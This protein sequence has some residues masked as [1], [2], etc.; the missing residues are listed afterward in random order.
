MKAFKYW[1]GRN[2][3]TGEKENWE[4]LEYSNFHH[5]LAKGRY[6]YFKY[7]PKCIVIIPFEA[8]FVITHGTVEDQLKH[9]ESHPEEDWKKIDDLAFVLKAEYEDWL[10]YHKGEYKLNEKT[11][12]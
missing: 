2:F 1:N 11:G 6:R 8:H 4:E 12:T 3:L 5:I 10:K 9:M 7:Y